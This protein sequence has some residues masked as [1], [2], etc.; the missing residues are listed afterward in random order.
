MRK[1]GN[2]CF[3]IFSMLFAILYAGP[4]IHQNGLRV[5]GVNMDPQ[6]DFALVA[7]E[8]VP[9]NS[10]VFI[11]DFGFL[12]GS[13]PY[14][15]TNDT[16]VKWTVRSSGIEA[17]EIIRF[18]NSSTGLFFNGESF[19][20][21]E[22]AQGYGGSTFINLSGAGSGLI[23][24]QTANDAHDGTIQ[25]LNDSDVATAGVI[26]A[27]NNQ[28]SSSY[29]NAYGWRNPGY[30][31]STSDS[32]VPPNSVVVTTNGGPG[33]AFGL[34]SV[35][36]KHNCGDS[37]MD[38]FIYV[39]SIESADK[40][41]W[42][43]R[44]NNTL[45]WDADNT[46]LYSMLSGNLSADWVVETPQ[47]PAATTLPATYV[48][49]TSAIANGT[50]N[51]N[52]Q[53][54][55]VTF[56]YG[57]DTNYGSS[58]AALP[59]SVSGTYNQEVTIGLESLTPSTTYH[60]RVVATNATGTTYGL[61]RWFTTLSPPEA[62]TTP[63][64]GVGTN[65]VTLNGNVNANGFS[66][67]V[68]FE[69]GLTTG[70][71]TSVAANPYTV[72]GSSDTVVTRGLGI[73]T[74]NTTYHYRVVA[75][76][77]NG[78]AYGDDMSFTTLPGSATNVFPSNGAV[79]MPRQVTVNWRWEGNGTPAGFRV[80]EGASQ[81][82]SDIAWNGDILYYQQMPQANWGEVM[83][84]KVI[85]YNATGAC[86]SPI[87]W[88]YTAISL[89]A[90]PEGQPG[91]VVY[92]E[93]KNVTVVNPPVITVPPIDL[94]NGLVQPTFTFTFG[95]L[96]NIPVL[97][98]LVM[99]L[100]EHEVQN[101]ENCG[102]A[103]NA[104]FP[105][106]IETT[107]TFTNESANTPTE[108]Y[109]WGG[110]SWEDISGDATF[111]VGSVTFTYTSTGRGEEEFVINNGDGTLPVTLSS[112]NASMTSMNFA[113]INWTTQSE[114]D[115]AGYHI[116]RGETSELDLAQSITISL[117]PGTN[118]SNESSY[119]YVDRDVQMDSEYFYW[120]Q[121]VE[122]DGGSQ[123]FGP[124]SVTIAEGEDPG[125]TPEVDF[126]TE[127]KGAFPN[128]FNPSTT[129]SYTL[130]QDGVAMFTMFDLKGRKVGQMSQNGTIGDN[131]LTWDAKDLPSGVYFIR[132]E[133]ADT[134]Q[135][136]KVMLLK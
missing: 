78:T 103:F 7:L 133:T 84:W 114:S 80:Y 70:Y 19:G 25:H 22:F 59:S 62:T 48:T 11:T 87:E 68:T 44:L 116:L 51:A 71:G 111:G 104:N 64:T 101:P 17:G 34:L 46:I 125:D 58:G 28:Y 47:P 95:S 1:K 77:T 131:T 136:R 35:L 118:S 113:R 86:E 76:N 31:Y 99:D 90:N 41:V 109:H 3:V 127:F 110:T 61:D 39:G 130:G 107:L 9:G 69:Y 74:S 117:I 88:S 50:V 57:L 92:G 83:N 85:P 27:L 16:T 5:V 98:C 2:M 115:I 52:D 120:L 55:T 75:T 97:N 72:S 63:A 23:I 21:I 129:F 6:E 66:T 65:I 124:T 30:S 102:G 128:P 20:T 89:P 37:E 112:F 105:T 36:P 132:M 54:T 82:G 13:L 33:N 32:E 93:A 4:T 96:P 67:N 53:V 8:N 42:V 12:N 26:S 94:G 81:V 119:E 24:Y 73:L 100:P 10:V 122:L 29:S 123:L 121:S 60:Y 56:E 126:T 14:T 91:G 79:E 15:Y 43:S 40:D 38:N 106:G 45:N 49:T 18:N 134:Y 108:L 135:I